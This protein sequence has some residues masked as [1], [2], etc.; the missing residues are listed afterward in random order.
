[1]KPSGWYKTV[2]DVL[3]HLYLTEIQAGGREGFYLY[4]PFAGKENTRD[5]VSAL[6]KVTLLSCK[7]M[8]DL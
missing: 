2:C 4:L 8:P 6:P 1:L 3:L 7:D 5:R